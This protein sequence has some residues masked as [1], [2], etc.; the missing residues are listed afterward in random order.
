MNLALFSVWED[1]KLWAHWN[2]SFDMHLSYL[3]PVFCAFPT[4]VPSGCTTEGWLQ[5]LRA[6]KQAACLSPPWVLSGLTVRHS[7]SGWMATISFVYWYGRQ[8]LSF[9]YCFS[10]DI[11]T[12]YWMSGFFLMCLG[13][14]ISIYSIPIH[15]NSSCTLRRLKFTYLKLNELGCNLFI[16]WGRF[17]EFT[18]KTI[19]PP[20]LSVCL[21]TA[22]LNCFSLSLYKTLSKFQSFHNH[23][24]VFASPVW[25]NDKTLFSHL[26]QSYFI[27]GQLWPENIK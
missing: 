12:F 11:T 14:I 17:S 18:P 27:Y 23:I 10:S 25:S 21:R 4:C 19:S 5:G 9:T 2:H 3:G 16:K 7:G 20:F 24:L 6:W 1:A 26:N 15:Q 22:M 8:N 13:H